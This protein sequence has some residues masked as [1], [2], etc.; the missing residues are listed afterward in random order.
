MTHTVGKVQ[1]G[2]DELMVLMLDSSIVGACDLQTV[3]DTSPV[4]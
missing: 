4:I 3:Q 1:G 2:C